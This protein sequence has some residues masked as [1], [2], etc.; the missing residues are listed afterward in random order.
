MIRP[1]VKS[2]QQLKI[3]GLLA[4]IVC[5]FA[6]IV[7]TSLAF[8]DHPVRRL[9][10]GAVSM[11]S[12]ISMFA[13]PLAVMV[14]LN[15]HHEL[16][17]NQEHV[18]IVFCCCFLGVQGLVIRT[19]CVEFMPF[20]LS[21]STFLMSASFALYGLLLHDFFIYVRPRSSFRITFAL[22]LN[23]INAL[24]VVKIKNK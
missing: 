20:Y 12:L 1:A 10:V 18:L 11:A 16:L 17:S 24:H 14:R 4:L 7:H 21:L 3:T 15:L 23:K 22:L 9:F 19:E 8:F 6:L 2:S 13:S 5:V